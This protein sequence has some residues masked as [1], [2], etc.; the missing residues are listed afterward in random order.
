[1]VSECKLKRLG[2]LSFDFSIGSCGTFIIESLTKILLCFANFNERRSCRSLTRRNNNPLS[3]V[4][5]FVFDTE[6]DLY[7]KLYIPNS[8]HDHWMSSI[9]NNQGFPLVLGGTNNNMLEKLNTLRSPPEWIQFPD[10]PY[11]NE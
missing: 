5:N 1:M 10:Y 6:F 7:S 8:K 4:N 2:D 9:A 11:D 3:S